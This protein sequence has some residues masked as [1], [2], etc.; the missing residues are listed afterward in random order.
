MSLDK[1]N[2]A[3]KLEYKGYGKWDRKLVSGNWVHVDGTDSLFNAVVVKLM[4]IFDELKDNPTYK[5]IGNKSWWH[6]KDNNA[7]LTQVK[8]KEYTKQAL[9]EMSRIK[10]VDYIEIEANKLDPYKVTVRFVVTGIGEVE[11]GGEVTI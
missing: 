2:K 6:L 1:L 4:M 7:R 3:F 8:I 9:K 11:V 5:E 10:S